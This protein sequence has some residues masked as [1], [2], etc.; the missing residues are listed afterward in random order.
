MWNCKF[1][2]GCSKNICGLRYSR[3]WLLDR[4]KSSGEILELL[5][6]IATAPLTS[7][8]TSNDRYNDAAFPRPESPAVAARFQ[9][10]SLS[11]LEPPPFLLTLYGYTPVELS[12]QNIVRGASLAQRLGG[13]YYLKPVCDPSISA[14]TSRCS[15]E[16]Y[17]SLRSEEQSERRRGRGRKE[18]KR[19]G[20]K[21]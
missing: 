3:F 8:V 19:D 13:G 17:G 12:K 5:H 16:S 14:R 2:K 11:R 21:P 10:S 7:M 1:Y 15:V 20:P 18:R 9:I 4:V 6:E